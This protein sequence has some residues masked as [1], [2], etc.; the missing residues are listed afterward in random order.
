MKGYH[1]PLSYVLVIFIGFL[2]QL[3][4]IICQDDRELVLMTVATNMTDGY[5]R[6]LRSTKVYGLT[7]EVLGMG[8]IW[9]GGDMVNE[10]GGGQKVSLLRKALEKYQDKEN[11]IIMFTDSYDVI[12]TADKDTILQKFDLLGA[13]VVFGAEDFCWPDDSLASQYPRVSFGYKYLNSGGFI[14]YAPEMYKIVSQ[15]PVKNGDDDQ[16]YY[17]KIFLNEE[18]RDKYNMK[19]DTQ[20]KV[21]QNLN[22]LNAD[23]SLNVEE[24]KTTLVNTVY[25]N[26]PVVIHGNGPSKILLN[27]LGN[28]LA[29]SWAYNAGCLACKENNIDMENMEMSELPQVLIGVFITK[30]VPFIEEMLEKVQ[31]LDYPK[32]KIDL[33]VYCQVPLHN[34]LVKAWVEKQEKGDYRSVHLEDTSSKLKEW[35]ARNQA[36]KECLKKDCGAFFNIDGD[37]HLDNPDSLM[38]LLSYN[39]PV[40]GAIIVRTG[41]AWS[42]FWGAVTNEG[43][44]ARSYDYMDIINNSRRGIWNVPY[45]YGIY[46][47]LRSVLEDPET[48]PNYIHKLL[49][50]DMAFATN[51][52]DKGVFMYTSNLDDYGHLVDIDYFTTK[53]LHN[54]L[55]QMVANR[56]DWEERYISPLYW[57][58]L[59]PNHLD[60][61]PCPDV[62]W[63]PLFSE[64]FCKDLIETVEKA[65][66]WSNGKNEDP[67]LAGGYENVPTVDTHMNQIEY[68]QEWLWILR[69]Y[70]KPLCEKVFIGYSSDA[71]AIMN[72]MVR[73]RPTEQS[74]LRPHHDSSTYTIN[75]GLNRPRIDY[76]G[77]GAHFIR[78]NCSVVDTKVGWLLMHP[79]RLTHYHEGLETVRGTRYIMVS[80]IDP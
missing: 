29:K 73:Y 30:A 25:Q 61:K 51:C 47:I 21:F 41:K 39:R 43:F 8:E 53:Y 40:L 79:G 55:W 69:E 37:V 56:K 42:T 11:T 17:T 31:N 71:R 77:G 14:G 1:T 5:L 62:Y 70:V 19:L 54:D 10:A 2:A 20:A 52:R 22:G 45:I 50:A 64:R 3:N 36:I 58:A 13:R 16:L 49:D 57:T 23:V 67:R 46:V 6:Y 24:K 68:E 4:G 27:S 7:T 76:E 26:T 65:D 74:F 80:F 15:H 18:L 63:F 38:L 59:T 72:F 28:Y 66:V 9:D 12:I 48:R 32:G 60:E 35:H 75:V 44:Y 33:F 78:Y 34:N